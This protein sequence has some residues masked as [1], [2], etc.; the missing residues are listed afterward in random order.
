MRRAAR[1]A[2]VHWHLLVQAFSRFREEY[3]NPRSVSN[4]QYTVTVR[5]YDLAGNVGSQSANVTIKN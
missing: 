4:G 3:W 1:A 5:G 2:Q